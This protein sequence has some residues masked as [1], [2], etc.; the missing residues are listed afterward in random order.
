M[1]SSIHHERTTKSNLKYEI[2]YSREK[3]TINKTTRNDRYIYHKLMCCIVDFSK[4]LSLKSC[5]EHIMYIQ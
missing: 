2:S 1:V 4:Q 5:L 3:K